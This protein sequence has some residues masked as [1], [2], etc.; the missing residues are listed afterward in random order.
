MGTRNLRGQIFG[1]FSVYWFVSSLSK[2]TGWKA[3]LHHKFKN[4]ENHELYMN[5]FSE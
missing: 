3:N 5:V 4:K 2:K 1:I